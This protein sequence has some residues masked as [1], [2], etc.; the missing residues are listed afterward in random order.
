MRDKG[1]AEGIAEAASIEST[2]WLVRVVDE[3]TDKVITFTHLELLQPSMQP[4]E[5]ME[6]T[7]SWEIIFLVAQMSQKGNVRCDRAEKDLQVQ[8][9][10]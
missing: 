3:A 8:Q 4:F 10:G 6:R 7:P 5:Y 2:L 9:C 1:E